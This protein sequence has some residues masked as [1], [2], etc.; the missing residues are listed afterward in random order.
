MQ[1][2]APQQQ[3]GCRWHAASNAHR[4]ALQPC[5]AVNNGSS[6][7]AAEA[8]RR[9]ILLRHAD[10][11]VSTQIPDYERAISTQVMGG[12]QQNNE[13]PRLEYASAYLGDV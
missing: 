9:I 4:P 8:V 7:P 10:S 3:W 1:S 6:P 2:L 13:Q 5:S 12:M 11:E